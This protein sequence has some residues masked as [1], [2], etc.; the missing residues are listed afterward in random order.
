MPAALSAADLERLTELIHRAGGIDELLG[1]LEVLAQD[2]EA[3]GRAA[4]GRGPGQST[5]A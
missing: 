5:S 2:R 3:D 1:Y 4:E